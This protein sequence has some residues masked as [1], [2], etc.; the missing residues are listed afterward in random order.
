MKMMAELLRSLLEA[1]GVDGSVSR[2]SEVV[3][4]IQFPVSVD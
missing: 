2:D 3:G 4:R 1:L